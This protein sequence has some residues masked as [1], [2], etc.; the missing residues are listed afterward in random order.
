[1]RQLSFLGIAASFLAA[2]CSGGTRERRALQS[3]EVL[4]AGPFPAES[5]RPFMRED[6]ATRIRCEADADCP[7]GNLCHPGDRVCMSNYSLPRMLD[8]RMADDQGKVRTGGCQIVPVYFALDSAE[9][10]PEAERSLAYSADCIGDLRA[11]RIV[12]EGHADARG[13]HDHNQALSRRR[14]ETVRD[15]LR[16]QGVT[17]DIEIVARGESDPLLPNDSERHFAYNRRVEIQLR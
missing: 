14:A 15:A 17:L 12:L 5:A 10:V 11:R 16:R 13:E 8:V 7:R 2:S 9:L 4:V 1:M 3:D 6:P